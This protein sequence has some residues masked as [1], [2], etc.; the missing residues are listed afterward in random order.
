M[1][2]L[3][4]SENW[5]FRP[6]VCISAPKFS[7]KKKIFDNFS[8]GQNLG[9]GATDSSLSHDATEINWQI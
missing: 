1:L 4:I 8:I 2:P 5:A 7:D 3:F 9:W 6:K